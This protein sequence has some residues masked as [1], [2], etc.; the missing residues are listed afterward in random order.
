[1]IVKRYEGDKWVKTFTWCN[2]LLVVIYGQL[3]ACDSF[4]ELMCVVDPIKNKRYHLGFGIV[5]IKF[6]NLYYA[7]VNRYCKIFKELQEGDYNVLF[8]QTIHLNRY[9]TKKRYPCVHRRLVYYALDLKR[10]IT[11]L[12]NNFN[13]TVRN[14]TMLCKQHWQV[15]LFFRW[16]KQYFR[17]AD[18]FLNSETIDGIDEN[19]AQLEFTFEY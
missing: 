13:I 2:Q 5:K 3:T 4:G 15:G 19:A 1:M 17:I 7:N 16:I 18:F 14:I 6:N 9:Q 8:D 12:I 10:A 11:F